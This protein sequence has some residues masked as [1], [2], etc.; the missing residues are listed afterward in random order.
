MPTTVHIPPALLQ[1]VDAQARKRKVS[2]NKYIVEA[3][4]AHLA[5][6]RAEEQWPQA[7]FDD[8]KKWRGDRTLADAV[9]ALRRDVLSTRRS[10]K[11]IA[12]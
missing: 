3:L 8:M 6:G 12:L 5:A 4:V 1:T 2:R 10:K 11:P 7:F 9:E